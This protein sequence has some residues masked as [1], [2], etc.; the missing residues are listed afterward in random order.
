ML[1]NISPEIPKFCCELCNIKTNN[2]KDFDKHLLTSKHKQKT[3]TEQTHPVIIVCKKCDKQYKSRV[4]LW[5]HEKKCLANNT[6]NNDS[7]N[8][9]ISSLVQQNQEFK[10]MLI[11]QNKQN[12]D[13]QKQILELC[14]NNMIPKI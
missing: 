4:G 1:T 13:L 10:N 8:E 2:K 12:Q 7:V 9:M 14:K 11:E 5:Y 3:S 6:N